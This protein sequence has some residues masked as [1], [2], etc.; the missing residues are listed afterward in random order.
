MID[1][2]FVSA[3]GLEFPDAP[4]AVC[5]RATACMRDYR[6]AVLRTLALNGSKTDTENVLDEV[7]RDILRNG[8]KTTTTTF[9]ACW[10]RSIA[11]APRYLNPSGRQTLPIDNHFPN[12]M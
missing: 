7:S 12:W 9:C 6:H 2:V 8:M 5:T 4:C 11:A 10:N 1:Q 3:A